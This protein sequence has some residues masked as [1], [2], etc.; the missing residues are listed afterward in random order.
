M[1]ND[2]A[3]FKI[4]NLRYKL[5]NDIMASINNFENIR[6]KTNNRELKF[7]CTI[8]II[9]LMIENQMIDEKLLEQ[10]K[11]YERRY[12]KSD[13]KALLSLKKESGAILFIKI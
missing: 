8:K 3:K 10:I 11:L 5:E 9:D 4:V 7:E 2:R 6:N 1:K 13:Q 12:N